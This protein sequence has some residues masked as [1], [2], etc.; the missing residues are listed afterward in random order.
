MIETSAGCDRTLLTC[1]A[2]AYDEEEERGGA[3]A[4]AESGADQGRGVPAGQEGRD[5]GSGGGCLQAA[6]QAVQYFYD[7]SGSI[8]RRYRR[9][10]EAGTPLGIT[11][12]GQT[13]EDD[14]VTIR[15]RD[16]MAQHRVKIDEL[17]G[18]VERYIEDYNPAAAVAMKE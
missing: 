11:A 7:Q 17:V 5:G 10:D 12:D 6:A 13:I 3:A 16:S 2:D 4:L 15:E 18:W 9:M 14:T 1:L 8:G